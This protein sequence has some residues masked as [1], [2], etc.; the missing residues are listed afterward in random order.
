MAQ[1]NIDLEEYKVLVQITGD[2]FGFYLRMIVVYLAM[3]AFVFKLFMDSHKGEPDYLY[4]YFIGLLIN[5]IVIVITLIAKNH[6]VRIKNQCDHVCDKLEIP[7][8]YSPGTMSVGWSFFVCSILL[9]IVWSFLIL[10]K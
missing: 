1:N 2:Y 4:L 3:I 10:M 6:Y 9:T 7:N 8:V 5:I